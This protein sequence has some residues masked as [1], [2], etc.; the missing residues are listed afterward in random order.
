MSCD[1]SAIV[2]YYHELRG[3]FVTTSVTM[4]AFLFTMKS[5]VI[6]TMKRDLYDQ[7][8]YQGRITQRRDEGKGDSYYG[9]LDRLRCLMFWAIVA[10]FLNAGLNV[11]LGHSDSPVLVWICMVSTAA[12]WL[13]VLFCLFWV[14]KNLK[15]MIEIAE[16]TALEKAEEAAKKAKV[17]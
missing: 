10:A 11:F 1:L 16:A 4:G 14:S 5:F 8:D 17:D 9:P 2:C 15:S 13:M 12:S 6:Q 3:P 7:A